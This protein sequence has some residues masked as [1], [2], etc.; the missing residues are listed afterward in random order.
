MAT[1]IEAQIPEALQ[2][3]F[4]GISLPSGTEIAHIGIDFTP[5]SNPY[6]RLQ[7]FKNAPVQNQIAF[8][9]API[10]RGI[11]QA[12]V[13]W[14]VGQGLVKPSEVAGTIRDGFARGTK[15]DATDFVIRIDQEPTVGSDIQEKA[16]M[17]IPVSIPFVIYP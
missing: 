1:H 9:R 15:I 14:P 6:V 16:W 4:G 13:F 12:S 2:S 3:H 8:N 7:L 5:T 10:R 17:Q 11:F